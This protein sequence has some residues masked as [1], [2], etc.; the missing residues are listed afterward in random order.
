MSC[1]SLFALQP[2]SHLC[3]HVTAMEVHF[4]RASPP[5]HTMRHANTRINHPF[6]EIVLVAVLSIDVTRL[7]THSRPFRP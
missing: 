5:M 6:S 3:P 4:S 2:G 1:T 7:V